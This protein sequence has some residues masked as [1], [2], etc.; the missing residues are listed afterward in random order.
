MSPLRRPGELG[1]VHADVGDDGDLGVDDVG[2]VPP[3]EQADLDHRDVDGEVGEPAER[4]GG[5]GLEV[6]RAHAG[7]HLEIGDGGDLLGELLVADRLAVA[8][9]SAR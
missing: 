3:A 8:A 7:E 5:D 4:R 6:R 9:R 1:V 2:R